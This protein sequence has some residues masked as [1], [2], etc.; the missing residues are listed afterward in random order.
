VPN[1]NAALRRLENEPNLVKFCCARSK[2]ALESASLSEI[3]QCLASALAMNTTGAGAPFGALALAKDPLVA[4]AHAIVELGEFWLRIDKT[5][6]EKICLD[7][8]RKMSKSKTMLEQEYASEAWAK[9]ACCLLGPGASLPAEASEYLA[10]LD[11]AWGWRNVPRMPMDAQA[12]I[13]LL[14]KARNEARNMR[15]SAVRDTF[16][17][18]ASHAASQ[19]GLGA[20]RLSGAL[21]EAELD[22]ASWL[23]QAGYGSRSV[24]LA[25]F[26]SGLETPCALLPSLAV[27]AGKPLMDAGASHRLANPRPAGSRFGAWR[28]WKPLLARTEWS[29]T[30][31]KNASDRLARIAISSNA[32]EAYAAC[33]PR[34]PLDRIEQTE[35]SKTFGEKAWM[36]MEKTWISREAPKAGA[37]SARPAKRL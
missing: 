14:E 4:R 6:R 29:E 3:K 36:A 34:G 20:T 35:A 24:E 8:L 1:F 30:D 18:R 17:E 22:D 25:L 5:E 19:A 16:L 7:L 10:R 26:R 27:A 12:T 13:T 9:A 21:R 33:R 28:S 23:C 32:P 31:R 2:K 11:S 15:W 37:Q